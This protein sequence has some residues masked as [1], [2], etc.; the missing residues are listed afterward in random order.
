MSAYGLVRELAGLR[1]RRADVPQSWFRRA[2]RRNGVSRTTMKPLLVD[3]G[4]L[5][6]RNLPAKNLAP[7]LELKTFDTW[8]ACGRPVQRGEVSTSRQYWLHGEC[9]FDNFQV[10]GQDRDMLVELLEN[11]GEVPV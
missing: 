11:L 8:K 2:C 1:H 5:G 4:F 9:L 6:G 10:L 7:T 3:F